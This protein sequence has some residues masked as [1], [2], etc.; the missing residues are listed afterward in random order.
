M[1]SVIIPTH[2]AE[3]TIMRA[4]ESITSQFRDYEIIIVENGSDDKTF[5][6]SR[7]LATNNSKITI[8]QSALGVSCAR[9]IG[10]DLAV[11]EWI[12]F[13][14]ADD[15]YLDG[16]AETIEWCISE[17]SIDM[18]LFSYESGNKKRFITNGQIKRYS[19]KQVESVRVEFL[20]NPTRYMQVW[21]KLYR[22]EIIKEKNIRFNEK[23]VFSE[24]SDFILRYS[25][26]CKN[27]V[28]NPE[29]IYHYSIDNTSA[30]RSNKGD[31]IEKYVLALNETQISVRNE[32]E[33]IR[34]AFNIY[35]LMHLNIA[36]VREIFALGC[37]LSWTRKKKILR[38]TAMMYIFSNAIKSVYIDDFKGTRMLPILFLRLHL[39]DMAGLIYQIRSIQNTAREKIIA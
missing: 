25:K 30:M 36:M 6:I 10:I 32:S 20:K 37:G 12:M 18:A 39:Y 27:V 5:D 3:K 13:L 19:G 9:N 1:I 24:D 7:K 38:M 28:F 21:S 4:V 35:I 17:S 15:Y 16:A 26:Y 22:T 31:K 8:T 34:Y 33:R 29:I 11:G 14:D 2:N 23:L